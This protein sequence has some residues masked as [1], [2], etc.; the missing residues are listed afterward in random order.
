[1]IAGRMNGSHLT[2]SLSVHSTPASRAASYKS[3]GDMDEDADA[4]L[5]AKHF[6]PAFEHAESHDS[7]SSPRYH[8]DLSF[9]ADSI[10]LRI[11]TQHTLPLSAGP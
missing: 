1:M 3:F 10:T 7:P 6:A 5:W 11:A 8:C 2:A 9:F 4:A